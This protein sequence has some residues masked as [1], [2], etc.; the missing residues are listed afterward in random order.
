[1]KLSFMVCVMQ[2]SPRCNAKEP[3]VWC[4]GRLGVIPRIYLF[5]LILQFMVT[6]HNNPN[7]DFSHLFSFSNPINPCP[8]W[9]P[10]NPYYFLAYSPPKPNPNS[11]KPKL[12]QICLGVLNQILLF[13]LSY[14]NM[15]RL[16]LVDI[17]PIGNFLSKAGELD[18]CTFMMTPFVLNLNSKDI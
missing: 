15:L 18:F 2:I 12:N 5:S 3:W 9:K 11:S 6:V 8:L 16:V 1:M 14:V 13:L 4:L 7:L 17:S 10:Y